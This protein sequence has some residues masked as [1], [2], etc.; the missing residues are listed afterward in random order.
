MKRYLIIAAALF[1]FIGYAQGREVPGWIRKNCISPDGQ[2]IAFCYKGDIY[3]VG[4]GGGRALQITSNDAYES[5]PMWTSD[6]KFIIFSSNRE[7]SKDIYMTSFEGGVPKRLTDIPGNEIP[8]AV[9]PDGR[10][11]FSTYFQPDTDFDGFPGTP[12]LFVTD[13]TGKRPVFAT[14]LPI[15]EITVSRNGDILY[16]DYKGYEDPFRKHHTSSVTRDI[17]LYKPASSDHFSIDAK[18]SF[19]KIS[20]FNGEDRNPVFTADGDTFYYLSEEGCKNINLFKSSISDPSHSTQ[21]TFETKNPVRYISVADNGTVSYSYN[22]NLYVIKDGGKPEK[23]D[24][25]INRDAVEDEMRKLSFSNGATAMSI[26][27]NGKEI[28][29]VIRGDVFVTSTEYKTTKRIT[30]TPEQERDVCFSKDGRELFY[31]AERNGHWGI[32]KTSLTEKKDKYFTYSVKMKEELFSDEGE[33]CFQP[34]ISPDGKYVAYL[35]DRTE[36]VVKPAKG[37]NTKSLMKD[38]TYSYADGDQDFKWSPDSKSLL[39]YYAA[40]GGWHNEDIALIDVESGKITDLTE[41][42]YNDGPFR[43]ALGG[44]A[45]TWKSDKNGYRSHGSWGAESDVYIM[46]FDPKAMADFKKDKED[47]EID[48]LLSGESEKKSKAEKKDS[49]DSKTDK[50]EKAEKVKLTLEGRENRIIRLTRSSNRY[51]DH[52]LSKDGEKLYYISPLESSF[53]LCVLDLKTREVKVLKR[54]VRGNIIPS[55]DEKDIY[56]MS[57]SGISK[58]TLPSGQSKQ[59]SFN[60]EYEYKPKAER[61]YIFHHIWKQ[62][63][64]KFYDPELHGIDWDYYKENYASFLPY[65]NNNYDFQEMLSEMLGE[66][67]GSHTG[68]RFKTKSGKNLGHLGI[69]ADFAYSGDGIKIKE[70]LPD[71]VLNIADPEIKEGDIIEA[72]DG[73]EIKANDNWIKLLE[74]KAGKKVLIT[75]STG[76]KKGKEIMIEPSFTDYVQLYERWVRQREAMVKELSGGRIGYV[77]VKGMDSESFR[78][79][80]S[81]ALGKYRIC[82]AL[83]VDTRHNGGGWLHDDLATFLSGKAYINFSPRGQYIATEPYNKWTKPSCVLMSE[84]NYSDASGFPYTYR[85]MGIG[86]LIGTPVPGTMTAVW[87]ESQ[88]NASIVFGIPQVG[89]YG[90]KEGRYLENLEI[91]PDIL[92]YNDPASMLNGKDKQLEGAVSAMLKELDNK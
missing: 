46:F 52:Y 5:D 72:I 40:N 67:N 73:K 44:K 77:H 92:I 8:K 14:S 6:S 53:G 81:K 7:G 88:I 43:W 9:L 45:M 34:D 74:D 30:N 85:T 64:E 26:S 1:F 63:K 2:T 90:I 65:I 42:G 33:T 17:W 48:R 25:Y 87:W 68:A 82:E 70:V 49:T 54:G 15:S 57:G 10:I 24:I 78:E 61:T 76:G 39:T 84:D 55:P 60:G 32:Y 23:M 28:A 79:V 22:G 89:S 37:G 38:A 29:V 86:K 20:T 36:L 47:K 56:L 80:Y 51:G 59:I 11:V 13:T 62:V 27:P 21:L 12:Q 71:G 19:K 75:I 91:E 35:R 50:V 18:G 83:I 16:E 31:S 41:S 4:I 3:T 69:L 58:I 66:L